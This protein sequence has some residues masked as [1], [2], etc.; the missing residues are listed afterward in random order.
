[1]TP[2]ETLMAIEAATWRMEQAQ[3]GRAWLAWHT[4]ALSRSRRMP[5]LVRLLGVPDAKPLEGEE[6]ERRRREF[7]EMKAAWE[8]N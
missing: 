8:C 6:L 7:E 1:M 3:K 4:A 2:K 5:A